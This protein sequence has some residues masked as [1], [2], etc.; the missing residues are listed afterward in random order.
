MRMPLVLGMTVPA[1]LLVVLIYGGMAYSPKK[2]QEYP[3]QYGLNERIAAA[4]EA[5]KIRYE[6]AGPSEGE[7][8]IEIMKSVHDFGVMSLHEIGQ[9]KFYIRSI[10]TGRVD[11]MDGGKSCQ[12]V[13]FRIS[14]R[15]LEPGE[16]AE[17]VMEWKTSEPAEEYSQ[18]VVLRT[19]CASKPELRLEVK[20]RVAETFAGQPAT[21]AIGR[22]LPTNTAA[23][24]HVWVYSHEWSEINDL[25]ARSSDSRFEVSID[26]VME[27][28]PHQP[29]AKWMRRLTLRSP[30]DLASGN[31][32]CQVFVKGTSPTGQEVELT[33]PVEGYVTKR[34]TV[35]G[36]G[37][38]GSG[39]IEFGTLNPFE[40]ATKSFTVRV[41]DPETSLSISEIQT[42]LK[43]LVV[44]LEPIE[45]AEGLYRLRL[46]IPSDRP[47]GGHAGASAAPLV[48]TFNHPRV[49]PLELRVAYVA[50]SNLSR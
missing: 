40:G 2:R 21:F 50:L 15:Q 47:A 35:S 9:T 42:E 16:L 11:L 29:N 22:L 20:G 28:A 46:T 48:I 14:D 39:L 18:V 13:G 27:D 49:E 19:N 45:N 12:C 36:S 5:T 7:P 44:E 23:E 41:N 1:I 3:A 34:L 4:R 38:D 37:I 10:G 24:R 33:I 8:R 31:L 32:S 30:E 17:V 43:F 25:T 6:G 26:D